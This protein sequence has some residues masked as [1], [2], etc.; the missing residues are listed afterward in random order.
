MPVELP[1]RAAALK[2]IDIYVGLA[3]ENNPPHLVRA[4]LE[5]LRALASDEP[6]F[7]SPLFTR[8]LHVPPTRYSLRL[9]NKFY[10]HMK[11]TLEA[12][13]D[14]ST[15]L[16]RA[17]THDGHVC[18][19]ARSPEYPRFRALMEHNQKLS[20]AIDTAWAAAGLRTFKTYLREDLA[21][22]QQSAQPPA[23]PVRPPRAAP[24]RDY[25]SGIE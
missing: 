19:P 8:D 20:E 11:L 10:P 23:Q 18:P 6:F 2:A 14:E 9:G 17:D 16:F 3:Y 15:F 5:T 12:A 25:K 21:R 7:Q 22:R 1:N 24:M 13:P 4:Q